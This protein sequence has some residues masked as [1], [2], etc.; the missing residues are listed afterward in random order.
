[1][2]DM[3]DFDKLIKE[4]A[5]QASYPYDKAAWKSYKR[6]TGLHGGAAKYWIA[7]TASIVAVGSFLLFKQGHQVPLPS[8]QPSQSVVSA[9]DSGLTSPNTSIEVAED[10]LAIQ[11]IQVHPKGL[12]SVSRENIDKIDKTVEQPH[13]ISKDSSKVTRKVIHGKPIVIDV[14]TITRMVPTDEEIKKGHS[15][16]F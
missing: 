3:T 10:T 15:R 9:V 1:M 13:S 12:R 7:G 2:N 4:K 5:E 8:D 11:K 14:D 16:L 6:K